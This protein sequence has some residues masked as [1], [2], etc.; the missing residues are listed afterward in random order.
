MRNRKLLS[1]VAILA[2]L[3]VAM[4]LVAMPTKESV[5]LY[6]PA[7]LVG[8]HL[9]AGTYRLKIEGDTVTVRSSKNNQ[10]VAEVQG[11]WVETETKARRSSVL[12]NGDQIKEFRFSGKK[13][14]LKFE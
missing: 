10:V 12:L 7:T 9:D 5:T 3:A 11:Q 4:P 14:V 1:L 6:R 2:V 8:Q 13:H